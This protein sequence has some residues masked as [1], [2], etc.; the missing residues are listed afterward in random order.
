MDEINRWADID[1][2][3]LKEISKRFHAYHDYIQ[4]RFVC[5]Q[6]R[7]KL[8]KIPNENKIPW[9][10]LPDETVKN[11]SD[12]DKEIHHLMQLGVADD[13]TLDTCALEEKNIYHIMLPE[14]QSYDKLIR[15]SCHGW[16]IVVSISDG[17]IQM[18]NPFTNR[19][20]DLPPIST[21]PDVIDYQP[22]NHGN[23]YTLL[24]YDDVTMTEER[25]EVHRLHVVKVIINSSPEYDIENFVAVVIFGPYY[26][27]LAFYKP[28]NMRWVEFSGLEFSRDE[29]FHDIIFFQEKIYAVNY[30]GQLYEFDTKTRSGLKGGIHESR[31]PSEIPL[32]PVKSKYLI[33]C[34]NGSL[35]MLV[36]HTGRK[37]EE[38]ETLKFDIYELKR[39]RKEWST[40]DNLGNSI[41][42]IGFNSSVQIPVPSLSKGNQIWFTDNQIDLQS[43]FY[44]PVAQD[45]GIFD[46]D[47]GNFQRVLPEVKF[48]CPPLRL[49]L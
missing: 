8:P 30:Y 7:L 1:E 36:R 43:S 9:L 33:G 31:P 39:N 6:W 35:L 18:L 48:F 16:L 26:R 20:L 32:G 10:L 21:L 5:K 47:Y 45:I 34:A 46:L 25:D 12:E 38:F 24:D 49:L 4:L 44:R 22:D 27:R 37:G 28:G 40:I 29:W 41:L 23:E 2:D 11:H 13:E 42:V 19:R 17:T 3:L 15:G 14:M